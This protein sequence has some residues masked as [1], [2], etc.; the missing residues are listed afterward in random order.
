MINYIKS[1]QSLVRKG[2]WLEYN[3]YANNLDE[4]AQEIGS[5]DK[6]LRW[7]ADLLYLAQRPNRYMVPERGLTQKVPKGMVMYNEDAFRGRWRCRYYDPQ[8]FFFKLFHDGLI[9]YKYVAPGVKY[10]VIVA[11][12]Q[13]ED[14]KKNVKGIALTAAMQLPS[15]I[16]SNNFL[17]L[18]HP[19]AQ[20]YTTE[21]KSSTPHTLTYRCNSPPR[22][23]IKK[24]AKFA[25]L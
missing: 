12:P 4:I 8:E 20:T 5:A 15:K 10:I 23:Q 21:D 2:I 14:P 25:A 11:P 9:D 13:K 19:Q 1:F 24:A 6:H 3:H 18:T 22:R 17:S 7:W 16:R